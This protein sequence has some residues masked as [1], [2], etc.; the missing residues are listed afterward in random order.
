MERTKIAAIVFVI[1]AGIIASY[2]ILKNF[3]PKFNSTKSGLTEE[4]STS[5]VPQNPIKWLSETIKKSGIGDLFSG[6]DKSLN[7]SE[8]QGL[9][10]PENVDFEN[11]NLTEFVAKSSFTQMKNLDQSGQDPFSIDPNDPTSKEFIEKAVAGI[12][13]PLSFFNPIVDEKDL[14][15]SQDNS[16]EVKIQYL[17]GIEQISR[18]RLNNLKYFRDI[19]QMAKD[20]QTDCLTG[21]L[22]IHKELAQLQM[23]LLNDYLNLTVPQEWLSFHKDSINGYKKANLIYSALAG[24]FQDPIRGN[25]AIQAF[26]QLVEESEKIQ[27]AFNVKWLEM[28]L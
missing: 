21:G 28:G 9:N 1:S 12:G 5:S 4:N 24:C 3:A 2:A 23:N 18:N 7:V 22:S 19:E 8:F 14:K 27:D 11:I 26:P 6:D 10:L 20:I 16:K 15:I 25:L 17:R 13:D